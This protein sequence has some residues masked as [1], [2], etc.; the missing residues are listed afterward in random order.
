[1]HLRDPVAESSVGIGERE[2]AHGA[3]AAADPQRALKRG[4]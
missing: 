3:A 2:A 4:P 1:M